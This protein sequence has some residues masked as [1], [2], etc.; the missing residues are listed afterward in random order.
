ME[1]NTS[2]ENSQI[3][4]ETPVVQVND[5]SREYV[6]QENTELTFISESDHDT[7]SDIINE[8]Y[9]KYYTYYNISSVE[10]AKD[11]HKEI[12]KAIINN[13]D[14]LLLSDKDKEKIEKLNG[15]VIYHYEKLI[16]N[17]NS[18]KEYNHCF[19]LCLKASQDYIK[20]I[21]NLILD[22]RISLKTTFVYRQNTK[23][24]IDY[25][26]NEYNSIFSELDQDDSQN[27]YNI[28]FHDLGLAIATLCIILLILIGTLVIGGAFITFGDAYSSKA[29]QIRNIVACSCLVINIFSVFICNKVISNKF[30]FISNVRMRQKKYLLKYESC[31]HHPL[32]KTKLPSIS[33]IRAVL[34][35][36]RDFI[37]TVKKIGQK[38]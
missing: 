1:I 34:Q 28:R 27:T 29:E 10:N 17:I 26:A 36:A 30:R 31:K 4:A 13:S 33:S 22:K 3:S 5:T 8:D 21:D 32:K 25:L 35:L 2:N 14:E 7:E 11:I 16:N 37:D 12:H 19:V 18:E 9:N 15:I 6:V 20:Y 38:D 24:D 23:A